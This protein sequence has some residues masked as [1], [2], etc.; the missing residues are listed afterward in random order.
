MK[1]WSLIHSE[2]MVLEQCIMLHLQ[3][4]SLVV[5]RPGSIIFNKDMVWTTSYDLTVIAGQDIIFD[6]YVGV[7]SGGNIVLKAGIGN[8]EG[9]LQFR[10]TIDEYNVARIHVPND[11]RVIIHY[12]PERPHPAVHKFSSGCDYFRYVLP[13][14]NQQPFMLVHDIYDLANIK[15]S[16]HRNYALARDIDA[17]HTKNWYKGQGFKPIQGS[18]SRIFSGHFDG[19]GFTIHGLVINRPN[20]AK[21]GLF[22]AMYGSDIDSPNTFANVVFNNCMITGREIVG[23]ATGMGEFINFNNITLIKSQVMGHNIT[24]GITGIAYYS[25]INN[26]KV[27]THVSNGDCW[28]MITGINVCSNISSHGAQDSISQCTILGKKRCFI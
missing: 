2:Y 1:L 19:N 9:K 5:Q 25:N 6:Y 23:L 3:N 15:M 22:A 27:D 20:D 13:A 4:A 16:L 24:G 21:V 18:D 26:V 10:P 17:S 8:D 28:R 11:K 12:H 14:A 7:E